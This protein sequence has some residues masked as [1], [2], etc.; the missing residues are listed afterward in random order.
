MGHRPWRRHY[1]DPDASLFRV[2]R[3]RVKSGKRKAVV[4]RLFDKGISSVMNRNV[5]WAIEA[6]DPDVLYM[7]EYWSDLDEYA[8][9]SHSESDANFWASIEDLLADRMLLIE[10]DPIWSQG[11]PEPAGVDI[12]LG[13][14][15][16]GTDLPA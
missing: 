6:D 5:L 8:N 13:H 16:Q 14:A 12:T 3:V 2:Y 9:A 11:L 15:D 10:A 1:S 4:K 7:A